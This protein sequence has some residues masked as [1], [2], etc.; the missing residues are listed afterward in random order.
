[1]WLLCCC[2]QSSCACEI[3]AKIGHGLIT[4]DLVDW[5]ISL[6]QEEN[7]G[8]YRSLHTHTRT[9]TMQCMLYYLWYEPSPG[10]RAVGSCVSRT[11]S[12][13]RK[14]RGHVW[15]KCGED[16]KRDCHAFVQGNTDD[17]HVEGQGDDRER[18]RERRF[19]QLLWMFSLKSWITYWRENPSIP[20][21]G[22]FNLR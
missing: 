16:G 3:S 20:I 5:D 14:E 11:L 22:F 7:H 9:H 13:R 10:M 8:K 4:G 18:G 6:P 12:E 21:G 19:F 1:M 17:A 15:G 2:L